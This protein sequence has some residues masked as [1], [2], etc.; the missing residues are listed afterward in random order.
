MFHSWGKINFS[1]TYRAETDDNPSS[2]H[3]GN[4]CVNFMDAI[5]I[6]IQEVEART[7]SMCGQDTIPRPSRGQG[8]EV[9]EGSYWQ[10]LAAEKPTTHW[11][12]GEG[13]R[14]YLQE[15]AN[16]LLGLPRDS[17]LLCT[18]KPEVLAPR[19]A[20]QFWVFPAHTAGQ[21]RHRLFPFPFWQRHKTF[22]FFVLFSF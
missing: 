14:L 16:F 11:G 6:H 19:T 10:R 3:C 18:D 12:I 5:K 2:V 20:V 13:T 15:P 1:D 8:L 7:M 22:F 4:K 21:E 9:L 17:K